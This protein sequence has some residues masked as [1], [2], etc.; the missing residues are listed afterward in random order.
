[1]SELA[2][3]NL[4]DQTSPYLLQHQDNPVHWQPWG[5]AALKAAAEQKKPILLSVGYAACHWCHVMAH[6]SFEAV[7][8]AEV[9]NDLFINIKVDREERPD[10]DAIYQQSLALMGQQ[11]GWPLTMFLTPAGEP[12]WG[13]TY[14]PDRPAYGRP[15]FADVLR[16][17]SE[18]YRT[19]PASVNKNKEALL[20]A[21]AKISTPN[22]ENAP[23]QLTSDLLDQV[24]MH[25]VKNVDMT[26]GGIGQ[27]PKFP[28]TTALWTIWRGYLRSGSEQLA[29]PV[30]LSLRQMCQ[31]GI[32]D[33]L[34]GGFSRY[35]TDEKWLAPHFEKML[36]DNALLVEILTSLWSETGDD[37][38]KARIYETIQWLMREMI[39]EGGAFASSLDAD[40]EGVEG[41]FYVW[42]AA[43]I[44]HTL[45]TDVNLFNDTYNVT[46]NGNW[47]GQ[48]ILNRSNSL[49]LRSDEEEARLAACRETLLALRAERVRPGWDDKILADWNGL[50]I[51]ALAQ[52][53]AT[54]GESAW[55]AAAIAAYDFVDVNLRDGDR[56]LHA[57]RAGKAQHLAMLD[58]YT[59]L[60]TAALKLYQATEEER[61]LQSAQDLVGQM[62][63]YHWDNVN[64]GYYF[65]ANDAE[66]LIAR[67]R[68]ANDQATP[69]G[70]GLAGEVLARLWYLTG[71]VSYRER[72]DA[73]FDAF[74][75][76]VQNNFF[77]LTTLLN[78]ADLYLNAVQVVIVGPGDGEAT[79]K[80]RRIAHQDGNPN[81]ILQ[82]ID[83][84]MKLP[85]LHPAAGKTQIDGKAT[86]YVC[87][88]SACSLP[89]TD[90]EALASQ[91]KNPDI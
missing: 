60:A 53:G 9:M 67:Q 51:A 19:D 91:L 45:N 79:E 46:S 48:N 90:P 44:E 21:L 36:Y 55:I 68:T 11:G 14:F 15:G 33:H 50:M 26:Y 17:V 52:A 16:R 77:P 89:I 69:S 41:K 87:I 31:G 63:R 49:S 30:L 3:N 54:H 71:D 70:N 74:T 56:L 25:M 81:I 23:L 62:D 22:V 84:G 42:S 13:G 37:L 59:H 12:F 85:E 40:S 6:E 8:I 20:E 2:R 10:I 5:P 35:S 24:A 72:A 82:R 75:P 18:V 38:F 28:H 64:G 29:E 58:D 61:F 73:L 88:G 7:D 34:G 43:D 27:A 78:S 83:E 32:Y 76:E 86:A 65:T 47:E 39:G 57:Y 66:G 4:A 1:M 80:L